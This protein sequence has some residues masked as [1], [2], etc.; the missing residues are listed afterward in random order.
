M[1][2]RAHTMLVNFRR[3]LG[4]RERF[5]MAR[6][7]LKLGIIPEDITEETDDPALEAK[8]QATIKELLNR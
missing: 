2:G 7:I 1:K 8:L 6:L 3:E 5:G 4:M